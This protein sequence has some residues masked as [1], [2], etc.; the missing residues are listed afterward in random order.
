MMRDVR[1][2]PFLAVA[3]VVALLVAPTAA[4]PAAAGST[5]TLR[6]MTYNLNFGNPDHEATLDAIAAGD[7]DVVLLQEVTADWR[8]QLEARFATQYPHQKYRIHARAAGG[9]AVLSKHPI[10]SEELW[11]PPRGGWFPASRV[12]VDAPFGALQLLNVHLRPNLDGGSWIRG[13]HTTPPIRKREIEAYWKRIRYDLPTIVAGDF[14]EPVDGK[15]LAFLAQ[16]GM[17][18][19]ATTGPTTWHYE[20]VAQGQRRSLLSLDLDHVLIDD[21]FTAADAQ[22]LDTGASDHRPVVVTLTRH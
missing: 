14:N 9:L 5:T 18:R 17:S 1:L 7:A 3:L 8:R 13:W 16:H 20:T 22:V 2:L 21:H 11:S 4:S 6:L 10:R 19:V 15:A 12:L